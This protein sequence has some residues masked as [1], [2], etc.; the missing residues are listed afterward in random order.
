M[1]KGRMLTNLIRLMGGIHKGAP[2]L[3]RLKSDDFIIHVR[4]LR[5]PYRIIHSVACPKGSNDNPPWGI[6]LRGR[7]AGA[8]YPGREAARVALFAILSGSHP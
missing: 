5:I 4:G 8:R 1:I 7:P 3:N 2:R 6:L